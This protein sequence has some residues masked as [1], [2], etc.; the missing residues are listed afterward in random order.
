MLVRTNHSTHISRLWERYWE[1][2]VKPIYLPLPPQ[3]GG[4][5]EKKEKAMDLSDG[6]TPNI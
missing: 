2:Y 3:H 6:K 1:G 5:T 4:Q